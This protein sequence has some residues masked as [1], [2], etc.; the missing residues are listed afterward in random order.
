[1]HRSVINHLNIT[2]GRGRIKI[3][4]R[5]KLYEQ[6]VISFHKI[7]SEENIP[8]DHRIEYISLFLKKT[9]FTSYRDLISNSIYNGQ[10]V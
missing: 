7:V 8:F 3:F 4:Q 2:S 6:E 1:M 10:G 5:H 9:C